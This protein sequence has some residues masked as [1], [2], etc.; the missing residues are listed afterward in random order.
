MNIAILGKGNVGSALAKGLSE[1]GYN[2]IIS[3]NDAEKIQSAGRDAEIIILAIPFG[4]IKD[5]IAASGSTWKGKIVVD[6]TNALTNDMQL[7]LGFTTS[8]AEE[9]QKQIPESK[10]V[11]AFNTVFAQ[12]MSTGKLNNQALTT[13]IAGDDEDAKKLVMKLAQ[14]IGFDTV[15]AGPLMNARL[16]EPLGYL[17]IQLGYVLGLGTQIGFRLEH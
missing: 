3:G 9:L 4:A 12:H 14:D 7:A 6:V 10:V 1:N 11:K 5:V 17:N 8:G 15:D 2:I 16:L 13:F